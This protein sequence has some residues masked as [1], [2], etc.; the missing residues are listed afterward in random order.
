MKE[1]T[2]LLKSVENDFEVEEMERIRKSGESF[3]DFLAYYSNKKIF[4][5]EKTATL[6]DKLT[7]GYHGSLWD[8]TSGIKVN[9]RESDVAIND[10]KDVAEKIQNEIPA[11]L[12]LIITDFRE[13]LGVEN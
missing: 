13:L 7:A 2:A 3:N 10:A 9:R 1:M 4:F 5:S 8:Y 11:I 12:K 6:L